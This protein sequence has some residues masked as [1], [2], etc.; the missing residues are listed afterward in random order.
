MFPL[1]SPNYVRR[2]LC[3]CKCADPMTCTV[4]KLLDNN[5]YPKKE[6]SPIVGTSV[7]PLG[8]GDGG[9]SGGGA[10]ATVSM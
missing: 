1:A 8:S 9:A 5:N 6:F 4:T 3:D 7:A 2:L 10:S